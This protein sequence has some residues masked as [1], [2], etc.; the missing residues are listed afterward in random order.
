MEVTP[1][2]ANAPRAGFGVVWLLLASTALGFWFS[3]RKIFPIEN[4]EADAES[5]RANWLLAAGIAVLALAGFAGG[6][7]DAAKDGAVVGTVAYTKIF[8]PAVLLPVH[9][10]GALFSDVQ[11]GYALWLLASLALVAAFFAKV[12]RIKVL[13]LALLLLTCFLLPFSHAT[14]ALWSL[15]PTSILVATSGAVNLRLSPV[16]IALMAVAG[17]CAM[18]WL[19][20]ARP[21]LHRVGAGILVL[22]VGWGGSRPTN[23]STGWRRWN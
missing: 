8:W 13:G 18:A 6:R 15:L 19:A 12:P 1:P 21:R 16:W 10:P 5:T 17:F 14:E 22:M 11:P 9:T 2:A 23:S 3:A 4:S 7:L 20:A